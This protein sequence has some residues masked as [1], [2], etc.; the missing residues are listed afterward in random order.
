MTNHWK[1]LGGLAPTLVYQ[2]GSAVYWQGDTADRLYYL[3]KGRV[4]IYMT[5]E[6]GA[7]KTLRIQKAGG[8]F[9]EAAFFDGRP[10]VSSARV[11]EKSEI[12]AV[13]REAL[14]AHIQKHPEFAFTLMQAL[15]ETVRLLSA[16][17]DS[18]AFL[19][20]DR[21]IARFLSET[22]REGE[23]HLFCTDEE[24]GARVGASRVTVNRT[25]QKFARQGW[26]RTGYREIQVL[27]PSELEDFS[28]S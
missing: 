23:S 5:S 24:L 28:F 21:R 6:N 1:A 11:L 12:V 3:Q 8:V 13:S 7:E 16:Q 22:A 9:G 15:S 25:L 17:V 27:C 26:I 19:Q 18:M 20:A 10:R 2:R 14:T 4:K